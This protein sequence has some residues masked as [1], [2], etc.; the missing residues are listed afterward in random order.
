VSPEATGDGFYGSVAKLSLQKQRK[1]YP[2]N[3]RSDQGG[4][5]HHRPLNT[6]LAVELIEFLSH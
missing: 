5:S 1:N 4:W 6:P 3:S 2:E